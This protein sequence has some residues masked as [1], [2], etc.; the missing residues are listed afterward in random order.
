MDIS[1]WSLLTLIVITII[2]YI[3]P[4]IG[5]PKLSVQ[6]LNDFNL[7]KE[8]YST[9]NTRLGIYFL[10]VVTA[11]LILNAMFLANKCGGAL[12]NNIGA[13][14]FYTF[15]PWILIF[16]VVLIVLLIFPGFKMAFSD[17]V[18]YAAIAGSA[19]NLLS[20][21]LKNIDINDQLQ[22]IKDPDEKVKLEKAAEAIVKICGNNS[23][24]IN[25]MSP[26]NFNQIWTHL[27]P[28]MKPEILSLPPS[29][30]DAVKQELLNLVITKDNVGEA[31]WYVYTG[32]LVSSIVYYYLASRKCFQDVE[33]IKRNYHVE[34]CIEGT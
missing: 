34:G 31:F 3:V 5:K 10:A 11:Q 20:D 22:R 16:G 21:I 29:D 28:L 7:T 33:T 25:Q 17:V 23:I 4:S 15:I 19:H 30:L 13:A 24:L 32:I 27:E 2:Y 1:F 12:Q 26:T 18:G 8:Y 14:F 9:S 6:I